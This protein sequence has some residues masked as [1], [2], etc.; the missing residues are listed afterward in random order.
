[1][2]E[3]EYRVIDLYD[4]W[5]QAVEEALNQAGADAWELVSVTYQ[6]T[7]NERHGA[8]FLKRIVPVTIP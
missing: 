7:E 4:L 1:M 3:W 8:A 5:P 2:H 6:I